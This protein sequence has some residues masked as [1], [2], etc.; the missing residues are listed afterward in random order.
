MLWYIHNGKLLYI[1]NVASQESM[2]NVIVMGFDPTNFHLS[3]MLYATDW[4]FM[5]VSTIP[6]VSTKKNGKLLMSNYRVNQQI[7][8]Q[9]FFILIEKK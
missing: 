8:F 4:T 2:V 6:M 3:L 1:H 5:L 9:F 7:L